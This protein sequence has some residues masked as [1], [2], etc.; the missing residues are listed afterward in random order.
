MNV[1]ELSNKTRISVK[2]LR[3]L[4]EL[5][6]LKLDPDPPSDEHPN[7]PQMR[8]ILMRQGQL[9][10]PYLLTLITKPDTLYDLRKYETRARAQISALGDYQATLAPKEVTAVIDRAAGAEPDAALILAQWL[11]DVLPAEPVGH[12]WVAVRLLLPLPEFQREKA[13]SLVSL[14]LMHMR[15]LDAFRPY[16]ESVENKS[17]RKEIRYFQPKQFDI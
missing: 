2:S 5:K 12:H 15:K 17:G 4:Q 8:F 7:A 10:V 6:L 9:S 14:A 3:K 11:G 1:F 13:M 16:W